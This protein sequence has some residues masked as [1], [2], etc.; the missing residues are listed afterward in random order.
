MR[1]IA[2]VTTL[3]AIALGRSGALVTPQERRPTAPSRYLTW[4]RPLKT[5]RYGRSTTIDTVTGAEG[6][7]ADHQPRLQKVPPQQRTRLAPGLAPLATTSRTLAEASLAMFAMQYEELSQNWDEAPSSGWELFQLMKES[8]FD[9]E[10]SSEPEDDTHMSSRKAILLVETPMDAGFIPTISQLENGEFIKKGSVW[11][12]QERKPLDEADTS[13]IQQM[14]TPT[15]AT[16]NLAAPPVVG[17]PQQ[18]HGGGSHADADELRRAVSQ[19][20]ARRVSV[21]LEDGFEMDEKVRFCP[22]IDS[23]PPFLADQPTNQPTNQRTYQTKQT[24]NAAFWAIV[25]EVDRAEEEGEPLSADVPRMLHHVFDA[26]LRLLHGREKLTTNVTCMQPK[27]SGLEAGAASMSYIFDD[28][29]HKDLPLK[30]GRKCEGGSCCDACSR[31]I[32]DTFASDAETSLSTFPELASF[33]FNEVSR[34]STGTILQFMRLIE[35]VRRTIAFEYG[36]PLSSVL[37]LQTYSRKYVAGTTQKGGGGGEGDFVILHTDESTHSSYHYS[38]VLYLST[39]GE[40]FEGGDFIF[41]DPAKEGT[42]KKTRKEKKD[43]ELKA[44]EAFERGMNDADEEAENQAYE[45]FMRGLSD[46]GSD[47][48][49]TPSEDAGEEESMASLA[50]KIRHEGRDLARFHPT[51]GAAV[52]FSSGWENMHEVEKITSGTRY[53]VPSFFTTCPVPEA[54]YD[55]MVAG[56]P[57]SDEDIADD[58]LHLLLAHRQEEPIESVARVKELLMKWHFMCT[59]LSEH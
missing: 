1:C 23:L 27:F 47:D 15:V 2:T 40:D 24:T 52:I 50:D 54:A 56:K 7:P 4:R 6:P 8:I 30:E 13:S 59:P 33:T 49:G 3:L 45:D 37:P 46:A 5:R 28:S 57:K 31:N 44:I 9:D 29:A 51:R 42:T 53:A 36:L 35:R 55:Q 58:W 22:S 34:V 41:N 19:M 17:V 21:L 25:K 18:V 16:E 26:D 12:S 48:T 10:V 43:E 20:D 14:E 38:C 11:F 32:F 39:Q